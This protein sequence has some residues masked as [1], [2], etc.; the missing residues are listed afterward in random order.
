VP[1]ASTSPRAP[2]TDVASDKIS[3]DQR[4]TKYT[5]VPAVRDTPKYVLKTRIPLKVVDLKLYTGRASDVI[6]ANGYE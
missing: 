6:T 5:P 3:N 4:Q 1:R 2:V